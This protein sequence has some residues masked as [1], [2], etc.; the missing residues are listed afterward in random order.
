M[1][2]LLRKPRLPQ[3]PCHRVVPYK[4]K[5]FT[6]GSLRCVNLESRPA[7]LL[8]FMAYA[9]CSSQKRYHSTQVGLKKTTGCPRRHIENAQALHS[10]GT[11]AVGLLRGNLG[12]CHGQIT[13]NTADLVSKKNTYCIRKT[14]SNCDTPDAIFKGT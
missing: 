9:Y 7:R 12:W 5:S 13:Q 6:V 8:C 4:Y 3:H 2:S 1:F 11:K 10:D 14:T